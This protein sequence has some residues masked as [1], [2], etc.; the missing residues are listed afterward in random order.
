MILDLF[1]ACMGIGIAVM[2]LFSRFLGRVS[3]FDQGNIADK[4]I[5]SNRSG[6]IPKGFL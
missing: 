4:E 3:R 1:L 5:R 2:F 6:I